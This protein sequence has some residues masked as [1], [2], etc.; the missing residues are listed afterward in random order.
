MNSYSSDGDGKRS[1]SILNFRVT[2]IFIGSIQIN[3]KISWEILG[4][5]LGTNNRL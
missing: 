1:K 3:A 5:E 2:T 4:I